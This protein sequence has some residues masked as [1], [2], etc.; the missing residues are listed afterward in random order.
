MTVGT[1]QEGVGTFYNQGLFVQS[2]VQKH[3]LGYIRPLGDGRVFAYAKAGEEL[4]AGELTQAA[5]PDT[6]APEC[7][8]QVAA[9]V[10]DDHIFI[11]YGAGARATLNYFKDGYITL[12][13][14][15]Y[16]IGYM[17]KIRGHAAMT[18]GATVRVELY[19]KVLLALTTSSKATLTKHPQDSVIQSVAANLTGVATGVPPMLITTGYYFWNQVKGITNVLCN[20]TW[21]VGDALT[22]GSVAGS[23]MPWATTT[24]PI[25]AH[26]MIVPTDTYGGLAMLSVPGY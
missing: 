4:A 18:S 25:I 11:T 17:Y 16:G 13:M 7:A 19:D 1:Y 26:A 6:Y 15:A 21:A 20:G 2:A 8:V 22:P 23:L 14:P 10:G 3:R 12:V 24:Q 5:V 9:N